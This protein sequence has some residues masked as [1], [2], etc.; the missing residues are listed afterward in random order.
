MS[1]DNL[2]YK[3]YFFKG[4]TSRFLCGT[5]TLLLLHLLDVEFKLTTL[6]N[7]SI[8]ATALAGATGNAS[9]ETTYSKLVI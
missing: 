2:K 8:A 3:F 1:I 9:E 4:K 6:Q 5:L 7:I